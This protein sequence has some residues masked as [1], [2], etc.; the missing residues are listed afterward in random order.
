MQFR[1]LGGGPQVTAIGAG[2]LQWAEASESDATALSAIRRALD[3]GV[4]LVDT[5]DSYG[6]GGSERTVAKAIAGRRSEIVLSTK[7]G[8]VRESEIANQVR[9]VGRPA[10][11]RE[12]LERSLRRL[13]VEYVD[14]LYQHRQD[15]DTPIE[16]TVGAMAE[17]V[18][19]GTVRHLG[20]S[21]VG[22]STIRRAA[23]V[24]PIAAV[25]SEYSLISRDPE[26]GVLA[27]CAEL[28]IGFV[29]YSPLGRGFLAGEFASPDEL[30]ADDLRHAS[31][32][33]HG[34]NLSRNL[35]LVAWLRQ[36]AAERSWTPGQVALAWILAQGENVV[37]LPG[38]INPE[39]VDENVAAADVRLSN[40]DLREL[41]EAF[42]FDVAAGD[43][44][45]AGD[46]GTAHTSP[47]P[48]APS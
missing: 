42:P 46:P 9:F 47:Q 38:M 8:I 5:A 17:E 48:G 16:E 32:R 36:F 3:L 30:A 20:L 41:A 21:E 24:H 22:P 12:A 2:T 14:L 44:L 31:P 26:Q 27:T 11:V 40:D 37:A 33:L 28:G 6:M 7:F 4:T 10:Y 18:R 13:E 1:T 15:P 45:I 29:A 34:D 23:E 43:R 25:Q 39:H 35:R 19:R